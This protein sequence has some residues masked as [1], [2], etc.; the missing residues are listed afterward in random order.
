MPGDTDLS[1]IPD[2]AV[3]WDALKEVKFLRL[4]EPAEYVATTY[5]GVDFVF[6]W[7][8]PITQ[9]EVTGN[10]A[11][12]AGAPPTN[13]TRVGAVWHVRMHNSTGGTVT[14]SMPF[15]SE[16]DSNLV[17]LLA[18]EK[19]NVWITWHG[20]EATYTYLGSQ[21]VL[22]V[23]KGG[24]GTTTGIAQAPFY[25]VVTP[26]VYDTVNYDVDFAAGTEFRISSAADVTLAASSGRPS[27]A[28]HLRAAWFRVRNTHGSNP[29]DLDFRPSWNVLGFSSLPEAIAA[30]GSAVFKVTAEGPAESDVW[31]RNIISEVSGG[32]GADPSSTL[33]DDLVEYWSLDAAS[34]GDPGE[35]AAFPLSENGGS[36]TYQATGIIST[37]GIANSSSSRVLQTTASGA[38]R[39]TGSFT[40]AAWVNPTSLSNSRSIMGTWDT[41]TNQRGWMIQLRFTGLVRFFFSGNGSNSTYLESVDSVVAGS[42]HLIAVSLDDENDLV[43]ISINGAAWQTGA[44]G[45]AAPF[46]NPT[47]AFCLMGVSGPG[48][49]TSQTGTFDDAAFWS[50]SLTNSEIEEFW[51]GGAGK[52]YADWA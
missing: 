44:N 14:M 51:N 11:M 15:V 28:S 26:T 22:S 7:I 41:A 34:G 49:A 18:G 32:G 21:G 37:F 6:D 10:A 16:T 52:P 9:W 48:G 47:P 24:T 33:L 39:P 43:K 3:D 45:Y 13:D 29:I 40:A 27:S 2:A 30:G 4:K 42:P 23:A 46:F 38:I 35:L 19:V 20:T 8:T 5:T 36:P 1:E 12:T 25:K 31:V 50:R 17:E